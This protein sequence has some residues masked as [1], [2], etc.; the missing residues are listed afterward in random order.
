MRLIGIDYGTKRVGVALGDTETKIA[1]PLKT[2]IMDGAFWETLLGIV[3]EEAIERVVVGLPTSLGKVRGVG[4]TEA[5]VRRFVEELKR[6]L[7]ILTFSTPTPL[8][9]GVG[10]EKE[11]AV[12][13]T[14]EDERFSTHLAQRLLG[15]IKKDQ[16]A[17]A[18]AVILQSYLD[19]Y[20]SS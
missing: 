18:A 4:E 12:T 2:I 3:R 20:L 7:S 11:G 5:R 16:D 6:R 17:V 10:V 19:R 1:T 14:T 15:G 8:Y 13:V 9:K